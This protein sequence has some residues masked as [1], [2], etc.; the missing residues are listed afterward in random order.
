MERYTGG[1]YYIEAIWDTGFCISS[2]EEPKRN[3]VVLVFGNHWFALA[4]DGKRGEMWTT[5]M[6]NDSYLSELVGY[7]LEGSLTER[8]DVSPL[9]QF[10]W[11]N[12]FMPILFAEG[13]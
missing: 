4:C 8:E 9:L 11:E 6:A 7:F 13:P 5:G 10:I 2:L 1:D 12:E 3:V